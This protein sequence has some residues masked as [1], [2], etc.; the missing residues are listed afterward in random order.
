MQKPHHVIISLR[1]KKSG[2]C[3]LITQMGYE[4]I[5]IKFSGLRVF[6]I[7]THQ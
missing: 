7:R 6:V 1:Y 5:N 4:I 3:I 2:V